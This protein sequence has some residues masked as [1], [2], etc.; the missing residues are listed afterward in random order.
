MAMQVEAAQPPIEI[1]IG[2][3]KKKVLRIRVH[4]PNGAARS[5]TDS[6]AK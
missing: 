5:C 2:K 6:A 3:L 4:V 1:A